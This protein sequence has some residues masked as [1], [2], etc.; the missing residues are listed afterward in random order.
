MIQKCEK[1]D[2]ARE[3][4]QCN[5]ALL[6]ADTFQNALMDDQR[7]EPTKSTK[8][9]KKYDS[10]WTKGLRTIVQLALT[11]LK[12][13]KKWDNSATLVTHCSPATL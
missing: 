6:T 3:G 8:R 2:S 9:T 13:K 11:G 10:K 1:E 5:H 12:M 4:H 7:I